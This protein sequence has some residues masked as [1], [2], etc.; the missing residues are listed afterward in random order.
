MFEIS[1]GGEGRFSTSLGN[2]LA[3]H[4]NDVTLIA[5]AG[6][7]GIKYRR[8]SRNSFESEAESKPPTKKI[9]V[10]NPP[11][12]IYA[13]SRLF[14][15]F[16]WILKILLLNRNHPINIIHAQ[17]TGYSGLAAIISAKILRV[18]VIISS[19]SIRHRVIETYVHG[20][21]R[22]LLLKHEFNLD[23]FTTKRADKVI[24][25]NPSI[26]EYFEHQI[27][28]EV[29]FIPIPIKVKKFEFSEINRK[30]VRQELGIDNEV[31]LIGF[32]GRLEP[33]KN[34]KTLIMAF[35]NVAKSEPSIKIV[36]V[37]TGHLE[38]Q[39]RE[40]ANTKGI[41]DRVIF[42]G[43]RY[44]ISE[45]LASLDIF[46][47]PS[48][49]EGLSTALLEAMASRRAIICSDIPSNR[50]IITHNETALTFNP[51]S[52]PELEDCIRLLCN[53]NSLRCRLGN[54]A[55]AIADRYD[56]NFVF[57]HILRCYEQLVR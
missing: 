15:S 24:A 3:F 51:N 8:L 40:I 19:H 35:A 7:V 10:I 29:D 33:V 57:P 9:K 46:V 4:G 50:E 23:M 37:G 47:L 1:Y 5:A 55:K 34:L 36:F 32:V 16:Q 48:Y 20:R 11:Y 43:V 21:L 17:D 52:I 13:L 18:P 49:I 44:D 27:S 42:C 28:R 53:D 45:V 22:N 41:S 14:I 12:V 26:K 54:N 2:Y 6:F 30:K 31:T 25:V 39:L 56:E 38:G